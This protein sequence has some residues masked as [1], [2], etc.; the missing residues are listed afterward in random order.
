M[1]TSR[2]S[3][4]D[5][6]G[7]LRPLP[8][9]GVLRPRP[10]TESRSFEY[11]P[12]R[13]YSRWVRGTARPFERVRMWTAPGSR[14]WVAPGGERR[15]QE[16]QEKPRSILPMWPGLPLTLPQTFTSVAPTASSRNAPGTGKAGMEGRRIPAH[17]S[18]Q[19]PQS[20]SLLCLAPEL[21]YEGAGV[22]GRTPCHSPPV[23][24]QW[25]QAG[26][27]PC[28]VVLALD[29]RTV[30]A[31]RGRDVWGDD[32]AE[33]RGSGPWGWSGVFRSVPVVEL[34]LL[35]RGTYWLGHP[36]SALPKTSSQV[37]SIATSLGQE[38]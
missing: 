12:H 37:R 4:P 25:G 30:A 11:Q 28:R 38:P 36:L 9:A 1:A 20:L 18:H 5:R 34:P 22:R 33:E 35:P 14:L 21:I 32:L 24:P 29:W 6:P 26:F 10:P 17:L 2:F 8:R 3:W 16:A 13:E 7:N 15:G 19:V 31:A 23:G 27:L